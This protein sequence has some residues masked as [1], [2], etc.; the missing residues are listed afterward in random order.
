M[1]NEN[2]FKIRR[3]IVIFSKKTCNQSSW[4][5]ALR[6]RRA[7]LLC[8]QLSLGWTVATHQWLPPARRP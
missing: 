3:K 6:E 2:I 1:K 7:E 4:G 5:G 8:H